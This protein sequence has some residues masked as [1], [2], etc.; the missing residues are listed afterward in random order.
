MRLSPSRHH[1]VRRPCVASHCSCKRDR[2]D[3]QRVDGKF[4]HQKSIHSPTT[5]VLLSAALGLVDPARKYGFWLLLS[6]L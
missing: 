4:S 1:G 2:R 3:E 5:Q 6:T